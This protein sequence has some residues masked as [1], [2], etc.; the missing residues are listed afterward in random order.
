[1]EEA[2]AYFMKHCEVGEQRLRKGKGEG[3]EV[4]KDERRE[5]EIGLKK[6]STPFFNFFQK[7]KL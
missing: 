4:H 6:T 2:S 3:M 5:L 1:M 7:V